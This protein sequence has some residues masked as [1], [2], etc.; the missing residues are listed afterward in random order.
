MFSLKDKKA[1]VTGASRGIGKAIA[2]GLAKAGADVVCTSS[3]ENGTID[4]ISRITSL[5][6]KAYHV[7]AQLTNRKDQDQVLEKGIEY[8]G[9]LDILVN[10]AGTSYR[11]SAIE[12]PV[13]EWD[14]VIEV[15]LTSS[16]RMSQQAAKEMS[17]SKS[18]K[19]INIASLLSYFG[20]ITVP[21]YT[22]SK[23]GI[24]GLTKALS[25]EWAVFGIQVNA[26]APGYI[27]TDLT[28][29]LQD[30][31]ARNVPILS[32]IPAGR[33]GHPED[34]VGA[35]IFLSSSASDYVNGSLITVD[36][37]WTGR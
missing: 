8:L 28:Q 30:D 20:G 25:N 7:T 9:G 35:A 13:R 4:T 14:R 5:K 3:N 11:E 32:R 22:A 12:F 29:A 21:A 15:N 26:I 16:F 1:I 37:G 34:L 33:W 24:A 27:S 2:I 19:I 6:R 10:N 36:G 17:K 23:H 31:P 18:G